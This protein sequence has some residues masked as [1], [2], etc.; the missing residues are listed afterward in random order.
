MESATLSMR[1]LDIK[2]IKLILAAPF[3]QLVWVRGLVKKTTAKNILNNLK[4]FVSSSE[5]R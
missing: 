2:K 4:L 1:S 5:E 3:P